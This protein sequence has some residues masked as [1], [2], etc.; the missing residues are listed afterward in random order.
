[1]DLLRTVLDASVF[2]ADTVT[3]EPFHLDA[4]DLLA[5]LAAEGAAIYLPGIILPEVAAAVARGTGNQDLARQSVTL[6]RQWPGVRIIPV[7]EVL[8]DLAADLA[9]GQ[10]IR[11]CDAVYVALAQRLGAALIT[12]DR[13]QRART[14]YGLT[15]YSPG[16]ALAE[17]RLR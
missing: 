11:G 3:T 6:Y 17:L 4:H 13:Q 7:D 15:T 16:E 10:R 12:L 1:M 14:P 5:A 2:V 9:A 8:A